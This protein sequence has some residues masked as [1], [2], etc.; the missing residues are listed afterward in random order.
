MNFIF[1][2]NHQ[3]LI[4]IGSNLAGCARYLAGKY[5]LKVLAIE[6]Q[7]DLSQAASELTERCSLS[8]QVHHIAGNFLTVAEHLQEKIYS[9]IVSWIT[10]LHFTEEERIDLFNHSYRLLSKNAFF[11]SED[12][13]RIG[14]ITNQESQILEHDVFCRYLPTSEQYQTQLIQAGFEIVKVVDLS[15]DW[16]QVTNQRLKIFRDNQIKLIQ[17][18][19]E[20]IYQRLEYFYASI[21]KLFMGN[22]VGG[23]RIIAIK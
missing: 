6:L 10:I 4:Q 9:A 1:E 3:E 7:N 12:F 14:L 11:F 23:I 17:I 19:G 20:D 15:E 16:K 18:H 13:I 2:I 5:H 22:N 21:V 8:H